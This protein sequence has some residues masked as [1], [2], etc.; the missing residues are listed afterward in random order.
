MKQGGGAKLVKGGGG[1]GQNCIQG[2]KGHSPSPSTITRG[3]KHLC[4]PSPSLVPLKETL[5]HVD[6][7]LSSCSSTSAESCLPNSSEY[8]LRLQPG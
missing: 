4:S 1:G 6:S 2:G 5:P 7:L 8:Y 3:D